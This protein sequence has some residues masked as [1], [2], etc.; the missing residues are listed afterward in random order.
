MSKVYL[1]FKTTYVIG[2]LPN[3]FLANPVNKL[4]SMTLLPSQQYIE[5]TRGTLNLYVNFNTS[6]LIEGLH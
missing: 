3:L 6:L 4:R 2:K 1:N 5:T